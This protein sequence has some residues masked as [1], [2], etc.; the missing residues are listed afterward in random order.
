[1]GEDPEIFGR[2]DADPG[3]RQGKDRHNEEGYIGSQRLLQPVGHP[4]RAGG[5]LPDAAQAGPLFLVG[6]ID[7][8]GCNRLES[9]L[10]G[11]HLAD[12]ILLSVARL[13]RDEHGH[14]HPRKGR[15]H[16]R[17]VEQSP[18]DDCRDQIETHP[19][20]TEALHT[21]DQSHDRQSRK[22]VAQP[23]LAPVKEGDDQNGT[24]VIGDGQC[25]KK[26]LERD[27][28][29]IA[30]H[31]EDA[32]GKGDVGRRR[33]S[34]AVG[35]G[36]TV[37]EEREDKCRRKHAAEG[38]HHR[39][40]GLLAG[41]EPAADDFA[42]DFQPYRE[43]KDDHQTV[44][45]KLLDGHPA[46]EDPVD[47]PFGRMDHRR[48]FG[49]EQMVVVERRGGEIGQQH[50]DGDTRQQHH[51]PGPGSLHEPAHAEDHAPQPPDPAESGKDSHPTAAG[52]R[53]ATAGSART[54]S[55]RCALR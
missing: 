29:A 19:L 16:P 13:H 38:G 40:D 43:E 44:V 27:R 32:H 15:V 2:G 42:F 51:A 9:P 53:R 46:G 24:E 34:P 50:G 4:D 31:R 7:P 8:G 14:R 55:T 23:H 26:D 37:V 39:E 6:E 45:D 17:V 1:M 25:R 28:H 20:L 36:R 41:R 48:E 49:L 18:D 12:E 30:D 22:Q 3:I 47:H 10:Q 54:V 35:R 5:Q 52:F 33:D 11:G 21:V